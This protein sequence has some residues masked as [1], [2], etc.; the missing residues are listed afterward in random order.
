[1]NIINLLLAT[2]ANLTTISFYLFSVEES[3]TTTEN[4]FNCT[5]TV[6]ELTI[7][8]GVPMVNI[9]A[10]GAA[11]GGESGGRG[12]RISANIT[13]ESGDVLY[14]YVGCKGGFVDGGFNGGE[15]GIYR[16]GWVG[17]GSS[18][19]R[20][21]SQDLSNRIIVAGGGGGQGCNYDYNVN[22]NM[23]LRNYQNYKLNTNGSCGGTITEYDD[24]EDDE[25]EY[26]YNNSIH[27]S[28]DRDDDMYYNNSQRQL[29]YK[30]GGKGGSL[31]YGG[32]VGGANYCNPNM[33]SSDKKNESCFNPGDGKVT[34]TYFMFED[35]STDNI[36]P[37]TNNLRIRT[38]VPR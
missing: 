23:D 30:Y 37:A 31:E 14:I 15:D 16:G 38:R 11:G 35:N 25:N 20:Y 3:N 27:L 2:I 7:P 9:D 8:A 12:G 32:G 34:I 6:Q 17:G 36:I 13:V 29:Y 26:Y 24:N 5:N 10:I 1:M 19:V 4:I 18:D 33:C 22:K 21:N 28:D